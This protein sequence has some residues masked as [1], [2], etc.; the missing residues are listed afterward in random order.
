MNDTNSQQSKNPYLF[1]TGV[2][3]IVFVLLAIAIFFSILN[4]FNILSLSQLY[5]KYFEF[6]PH[7]P[8]S[9]TAQNAN[10][11]TPKL[12]SIPCP[13]D[14]CR[15]GKL[16]SA[17]FG[18]TKNYSLVF[19]LAPGTKLTAVFDG[20]VSEG[21]QSITSKSEEHFVIFENKNDPKTTAIYDFF[22]TVSNPLENDQ[23][24]G[25]RVFATG[26]KIGVVKTEHFPNIEPVSG[27][28]FI[29][30]VKQGNKFLKLNISGDHIDLIQDTRTPTR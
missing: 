20:R 15:S 29:F 25:L 13:V 6:L 1:K 2:F 10:V 28:N 12:T 21:L 14:N 4:Y 18:K 22:G 16:I 8:F 23:S 30:S 3:E 19:T 11:N 9:N 26:E 24:G 7:R 27:A 5:P 17:T